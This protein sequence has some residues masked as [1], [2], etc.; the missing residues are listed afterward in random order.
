MHNSCKPLNTWRHI[1]PLRSQQSHCKAWCL[2]CYPTA[3]SSLLPP[4]SDPHC[5]K[6]VDTHK[7]GVGRPHTVVTP[8]KNFFNPHLH[9]PRYE[10]DPLGGPP[11]PMKRTQKEGKNTPLFF[12]PFFL[13]N[14]P[15]GKK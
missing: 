15:P 4:E 13:A 10:Q 11:P 7:L 3:R 5:R 14:P 12:P 1:T 6:V 9:P 8:K 2:P